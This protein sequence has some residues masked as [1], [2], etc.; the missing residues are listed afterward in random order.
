[1]PGICDAEKEN[2]ISHWGRWTWALDLT[3]YAFHGAVAG[4]LN[5][6]SCHLQLQ[7]GENRFIQQGNSLFVIIF[8]VVKAISD[9]LFVLMGLNRS[10]F[11][12]R[13]KVR[14]FQAFVGS[15]M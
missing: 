7:N 3:I 9:V 1:M 11:S 13:R 15:E 14:A 4:G 2:R 6:R 10:I 12:K 8:D 5:Y